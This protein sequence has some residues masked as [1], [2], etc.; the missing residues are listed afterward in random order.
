MRTQM[1]QARDGMSWMVDGD[2]PEPADLVLYFGSRRA[3]EAG[4]L[5]SDLCTAYPG[6]Q[7][8]GCS[9]G[10][11]ILGHDVTD[12]VA[13]A[14]AMSFE[15]TE[16][17]VS[18]EMIGDRTQS[19]SCGHAIGQELAARPGLAGV[20]VL[21]D[22]LEVNGSELTRGILE[23]IGPDIPLSGGLAGDGADFVR[24]LVGANGPP[25][26]RQIA[27]IGFYGDRF[28]MAAGAAGGWDEFGTRRQVTRAQGSVLYELDGSPALEL[29]RRYLGQEAAGLPGTALLFPL[30]IFH[31]DEPRHGIV[32]TVLSIDENEQ[33]MTFAGDVPEG[34]TAQLM[35]GRFNKLTDASAE[36]ARRSGRRLGAPADLTLMVSCIGRRLLMDQL[37]GEEIEAAGEVVGRGAMAGFYSYGE[38]A[39]HE[40]SGVAELHNQTMTVTSLSERG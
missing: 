21:S 3:L 34:W 7:L 6:A 9:T 22:G 10:G 16:I 33:T 28:E 11:Q 8:V 32:R 4:R 12:D 31:P 38:I 23:R 19:K 5:Y 35:M 14:V 36:A 15:A 25:V 37:I 20:F 1:I 13:T 30:K 18:S 26:A 17:A 2:G 27:A 29:Y 40:I 24:T 39:P